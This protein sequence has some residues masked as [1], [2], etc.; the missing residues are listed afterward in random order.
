VLDGI[1]EVK[2]EE[3][4]PSVFGTLRIPF[5]GGNISGI[6]QPGTRAG[7]YNGPSK[8]EGEGRRRNVC[9]IPSRGW[10]CFFR[11]YAM[12]GISGGST[13]LTRSDRLG[14]HLY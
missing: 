8:E 1:S 10:T 3:R 4:E 5:R 2:R 12:Y 9:S 13:N 6:E 14:Y 7:F 11:W